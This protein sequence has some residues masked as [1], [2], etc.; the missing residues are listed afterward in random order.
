MDTKATIDTLMKL[1]LH[2]KEAFSN[3]ASTTG[4]GWQDF[5]DSPDARAAQGGVSAL[6]EQ[7]TL[8]DIG[9]AVSAAQARR[10]AFLKGRKAVELSFDELTQLHALL[11]VETALVL[12]E[13]EKVG[14]ASFWSWLVKDALPVL[15]T[16]GKIALA[17]L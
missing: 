8:A 2:M 5:L 11:D 4:K 17:V 9:N 12:K 13:V 14:S 1:G 7:L 3:F 6:L 15:V 10:K 16:V